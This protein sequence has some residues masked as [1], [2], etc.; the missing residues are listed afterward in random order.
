[1]FWQKNENCV[2]KRSE[3]HITFDAMVGDSDLFFVCRRN[4]YFNIKFNIEIWT[5]QFF[6]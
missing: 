4:R 3:K 6:C 5:T 1:M 2:L